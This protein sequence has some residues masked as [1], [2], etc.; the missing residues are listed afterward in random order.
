MLILF[1]FIKVGKQSQH[2]CYDISSQSNL[3]R[4]NNNNNNNSNQTDA[5]ALNTP[6]D[7]PQV[8]N[9]TKRI[10][11]NRIALDPADLCCC[12]PCLSLVKMCCQIVSTLSSCCLRPCCTGIAV[13]GGLATL[14]VIILAI[15]FA[16]F[17]GYMP[18]PNQITQSLCNSTR[19]NF[20]FRENFTIYKPIETRNETLFKLNKLNNSNLKNASQNFNVKNNKTAM[21][22]LGNVT[23]LLPKQPPSSDDVMSHLIGIKMKK[24]LGN[25]KSLRNKISKFIALQYDVLLLPNVLMGAIEDDKRSFIDDIIGSSSSSSSSTSSKK[26]FGMEMK[27]NIDVKL[28]CNYSTEFLYFSTREFSNI[29]LK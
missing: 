12:T 18:V 23:S 7:T 11:N 4:A 26:N 20:Y 5:G 28:V 22:H 19:E 15:L 9:Y 10:I 24:V 21:S 25:Q 14:G 29:E 3:I 16:V 6:N 27:I 2:C 13:L 8:N 1:I 17:F